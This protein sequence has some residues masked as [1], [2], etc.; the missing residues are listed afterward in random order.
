[1]TDFYHTQAMSLY[2]R[3]FHALLFE[4]IAII[5][6]VLGL[7]YFTSHNHTILSGVVIAISVMAMLWNMLFNWC[8]DRYFTAPREQR[9]WRVRILHV[10]LF[11]GGLLCMTLPLVAWSLDI[12]LWQ[13]FVLDLAMTLF[14]MVYSVIFNWLYDHSRAYLIRHNL[15]K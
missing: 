10:V 7:M 1:M 2:E 13:A 4:M 14:I 6:T 12:S 15:Q 9:S 11:E 5:L 3:I 8:F